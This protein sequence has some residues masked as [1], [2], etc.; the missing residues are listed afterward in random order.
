MKSGG[1]HERPG[2]QWKAAIKEK[3]WSGELTENAV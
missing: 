3:D 2:E 1:R